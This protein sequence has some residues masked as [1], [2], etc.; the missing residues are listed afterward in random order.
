MQLFKVFWFT[1]VEKIIFLFLRETTVCKTCTMR[2]YY[3]YAQF[4]LW[5][6]QH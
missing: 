3:S 1:F 4:M 5:L 6:Q 2:V